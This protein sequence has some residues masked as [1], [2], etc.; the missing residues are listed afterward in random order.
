[1]G[2]VLSWRNPSPVRMH[3]ASFKYLRGS[4]A[5]SWPDAVNAGL[6]LFL[7]SAW[8]RVRKTPHAETGLSVIWKRSPILCTDFQIKGDSAVACQHR[9]CTGRVSRDPLNLSKGLP[10][11]PGG[12]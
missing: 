9:H 5:Y 8:R 4:G 3:R 12:A 2:L 11:G 7:Y 1:M 10:V 6:E